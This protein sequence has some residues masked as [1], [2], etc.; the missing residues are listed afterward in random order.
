MAKMARLIHDISAIR[1]I[2]LQFQ[3]QKI[4]GGLAMP[5]SS[6]ATSCKINFNTRSADAGESLKKL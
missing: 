3:L 4:V 5:T 1:R 6:F 2:P